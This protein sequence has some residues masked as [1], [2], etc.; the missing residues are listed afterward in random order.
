[1]RIIQYVST[2]K[3]QKKEMQGEG[4]KEERRENKKSSP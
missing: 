3:F 1:M 2:C 4:L